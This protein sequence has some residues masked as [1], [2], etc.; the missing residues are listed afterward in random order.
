MTCIQRFRCTANSHA[1][2]VKYRHTPEMFA[3]LWGGSINYIL[4]IPPKT[5][6]MIQ[7]VRLLTGTLKLSRYWRGVNRDERAIQ[8]W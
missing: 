6:D 5:A 1:L 8:D 7:T 3:G 4:K 2:S